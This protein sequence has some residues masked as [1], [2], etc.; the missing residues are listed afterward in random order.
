MIAL[1]SFNPNLSSDGR[2][3]TPPSPKSQCYA[4]YEMRG[5]KQ[6]NHLPL[7]PKNGKIVHFL[8]KA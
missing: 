3:E 4:Q 8:I 7:S 2:D 6:G 1:K 5:A